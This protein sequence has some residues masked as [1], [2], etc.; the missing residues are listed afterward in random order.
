MAIAKN[1]IND[2]FTDDELS[3]GKILVMKL[4]H[5]VPLEDME[6]LTRAT[7]TEIDPNA[8]PLGEFLKEVIRNALVVL[9]A[10]RWVSFEMYAAVGENPNSMFLCSAEADK[11]IGTYEFDAD[12]IK[13][14]HNA[15]LS[16]KKIAAAR[17][18]MLRAKDAHNELV[19]LHLKHPTFKSFVRRTNAVNKASH[20]YGISTLK[21]LSKEVKQSL[22]KTW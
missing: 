20:C 10:S 12:S 22:S 4:D 11:V 2:M 5:D 3:V 18:A 21:K 7:L 6:R 16:H 8:T 14:L 19:S 17:N 13:R 15:A 1:T 9:G